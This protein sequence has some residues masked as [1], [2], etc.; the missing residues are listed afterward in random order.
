M[1]GEALLVEELQQLSL[2]LQDLLTPGVC[3]GG[4]EQ[5]GATAQLLLKHGPEGGLGP[6]HLKAM[7]PRVDATL[8]KDQSHD[9]SLCTN[10]PQDSTSYTIFPRN[11]FIQLRNSLCTLC[12]SCW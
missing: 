4:V 1:A 2:V 10:V 8:K 7:H 3:L 12:C 6:Q 9:S 11:H 5:V